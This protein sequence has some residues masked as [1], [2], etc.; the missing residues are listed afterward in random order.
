LQDPSLYNERR[1]LLSVAAGD[2]K[3]FTQLVDLYWNRV[4][5]HALAYAKS[6]QKAQEI[7]QDVFLKVWKKR[8][9]LKEIVDFKNFLFILGRNQIISS[10][11][12]KLEGPTGSDPGEAWED[13]LMP[14]QQLEY[15]EAYAMIRE[16]I[17]KLPPTRKAVFK[18]SRME[19]L[20]YEQIAGKMNISKN[21]VKEHIVLALN[22][23]R[24][25]IHTHG[26]LLFIFL[27]SLYSL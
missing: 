17:E 8:D 26:D 23:L 12:K 2:E 4:Y 3:A 16:G 1:L 7:T 21:T 24:T 5:G 14:D 10:L 22:F 6:S 11:R 15:K 25:Y 13:V 20:S 18:M 19:G 27:F 9:T